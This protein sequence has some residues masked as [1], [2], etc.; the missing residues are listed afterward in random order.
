M[1]LLSLLAVGGI[2]GAIDGSEGPKRA[3]IST[4]DGTISTTTV[5]TAIVD[6]TSRSSTALANSPS[7]LAPITT[8]PTSQ[9]AGTLALID[10]LVVA[11]PYTAQPYRRVAFGDDW[12][13]ADRDCHNTRAE[14]L[15]LETAAPVTFNPNGCTVNT[16]SWTDPWS[17]YMST[18][19]A[20]FEIDHTVPLADAWR[21]GAWQWDDARRL[22]FAND[23]SDPDTLNALRGAV[24]ESKSDKGPDG[25]RPP[26]RSTWCAYAQGWAQIKATWAL[27]VTSSELAALKDMAGTC[28]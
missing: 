27:T 5:T 20:D 1:V 28:G 2:V 24:N 15:M 19:A 16:G 18:S 10:S 13:D 21:S 23:L 12:I 26:L 3:L 4:I 17:G 25:W 9:R 7:T 6:S 8:Q 11:T 22:A 14:V